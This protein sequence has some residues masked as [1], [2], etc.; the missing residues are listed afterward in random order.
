[1]QNTHNT[2]S[3]PREAQLVEPN[4]RIA[5]GFMKPIINLAAIYAV[6]FLSFGSLVNGIE[7]HGFSRGRGFGG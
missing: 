2:G 6:G 3:T 5:E 7:V 4:R 1:M